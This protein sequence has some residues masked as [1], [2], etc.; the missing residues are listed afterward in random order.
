MEEPVELTCRAVAPTERRLR[1]PEMAQARKRRSAGAFGESVQKRLVIDPGDV[2]D[3][4]DVEHN[5]GQEE[6]NDMQFEED[7]RP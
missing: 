1:T 2:M 5:T 3:A 6:N 7:S 4:D